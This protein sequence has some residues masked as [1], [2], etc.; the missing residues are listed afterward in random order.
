M[1]LCVGLQMIFLIQLLTSRLSKMLESTQAIH[2][3]TETDKG[4]FCVIGTPCK[5]LFQFTVLV[6]LK[7]KN[8]F[9]GQKVLLTERN[10][11]YDVDARNNLNL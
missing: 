3:L 7:K 2:K 10:A 1:H 4:S 8:M 9:Y 11:M 6:V 5:K